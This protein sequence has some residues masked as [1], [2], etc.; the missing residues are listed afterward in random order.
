DRR[1]L[2]E[3]Q[4]R[5]TDNGKTFE[6]LKDYYPRVVDDATFH[7]ARAAIGGRK[8]K[9]ARGGRIGEGVA[10]LFG[11]LLRHAR[12]G[13]TYYVATRVEV[14]VNSRALLNKSSIETGA[15]AYTFA[16][17]PFER[18]VLSC[19]REIDPADVVEPVPVT[20]ASV[21]QGE[22]NDLRERKAA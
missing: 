22:L 18:A 19:L 1:V 3:F 21:L 10:N 20:E 13:S 5:D 11:G 2:G 12:D 6:V 16:Y 9:G 14:A 17:A 7:A 4:P 15:R 8:N